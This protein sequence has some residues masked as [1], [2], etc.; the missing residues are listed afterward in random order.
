MSSQA[1]QTAQTSAPSVAPAV[2]ASAG[3]SGRGNAQSR[4][5]NSFLAERMGES[6]EKSAGDELESGTELGGGQD[7]AVAQGPNAPP[8]GGQGQGGGASSARPL[9]VANPAPRQNGPQTRTVL[10]VQIIGTN[11]SP[12]ALDA[13]E[14]FVR[15]TLANRRDMQERMARNN[16]AL[17][18][19]P[20]DKKMTD[21]PQFASLRGTQ[22]F[23]GRVWDDVRGSGGMQVAGGVWAIAVPEENLIAQE[24]STDG[25]AE[26]YSV[27][28]HELAHTIHEKAVT[29]AERRTIK[30]LYDARKAANG[31][32]TDTYAS[33]NEYEYFSQ[34]TNCYQGANRG[35]GLNGPRW[36]ETNDRPMF[37]FLLSVYGPSQAA[38]D[39]SNEA[40]A[41]LNSP[42]AINEATA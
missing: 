25:Y 31:P 28:L 4:Y 42:V 18:I 19:I 8:G 5:G 39:S 9:R 10:G 16:V 23:D 11:V 33:A 12:S 30:A 21:L 37:D 26:G 40:H 17:V 27:G 22:T 13:C 6:T 32:W 36:L 20:S 7:Q 34:C 15:L 3:L 38:E 2:G 24:N 35:Q 1:R 29:N 14:A 41:N